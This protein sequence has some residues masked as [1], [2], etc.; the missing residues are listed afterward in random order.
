MNLL[1]L[2]KNT[3]NPIPKEKKHMHQYT[4]ADDLL[5]RNSVDKD[6]GVL[7]YNRTTMSQQCALMAKKP[8]GKQECI[9]NCMDSR[10]RD[11]IFPF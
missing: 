11:M 7:M 10:S 3:C 8:S 6:L 2:N 9:K 5:E 1:R 4:L